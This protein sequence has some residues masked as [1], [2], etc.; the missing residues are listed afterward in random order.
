[1]AKKKRLRNILM[2]YLSQ[3]GLKIHQSMGIGDHES[4]QKGCIDA[5]SN[6]K[7]EVGI[8]I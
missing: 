1:M 8:S 7:R 5:S 4:I 2:G 6:F 3:E